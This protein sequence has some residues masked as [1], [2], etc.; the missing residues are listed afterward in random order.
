MVAG[1]IA[2]EK[3]QEGG[4]GVAYNAELSGWSW[5]PY[6]DK[7]LYQIQNLD[8]AN[9]SWGFETPFQDNFQDQTYKAYQ[10]VLSYGALYGREELGTIVIVSAGNNREAGDNVNY[11]NLTN[12]RSVITVGSIN[13]EAD[14]GKLIN[15]SH[16]F[17]NPGA[18]IL[19]S[20]PGSNISSTSNI[21]YNQNGSAF[22]NEFETIQGTSF[23]APIVSGVAAL[24][25]QANPNLGY[26]DVQ[27]ILAYSAKNFQ[28]QNTQWQ[29][30]GAKDWNGGGLRYSADY[31]FGIVN[32]FAA[33]RLAETWNQQNNAENEYYTE[34]KQKAD[35]AIKDNKTI[36]D[37]INIDHNIINA[38]HIEIGVDITHQR[39]GDLVISLTSPSGVE[40]VL[41]N[42]P[43]KAPQSD[44][45]DTGLETQ[46][47]N[48]TFTTTNLWGENSLGNWTIKITDAAAG[49]TGTLNSWTLSL[50]GKYNLGADTYIYTDQYANLAETER[51]TLI[52]DNGGTDTINI[53][54]ITGNITFDLTPGA[55]NQ[56]AGK[57]LTIA[58]NT[59]IEYLLTGDG[60]DTLIGNDA[61][62][63]LYGGRGDDAIYGG[64]GADTITGRQ[65]ADLIQGG[66]GDDTII[67]SID[68][69]AKSGY[70]AWNVGSPNNIINGERIP[71]KP[72]YMT[73]D[74]IDGGQ[75][76]DT[77]QMTDQSEALFLHDHYSPAYQTGAR[78][79]SIETIYAGAGN[80]IIDL[81]SD[82][83][84]A[85]NTTLYGQAGND[86][87]WTSEGDDTIYGGDGEDAI[88]GGIGN[89]K[90]NG[91]AGKDV[92]FGGKGSD[93]FD[94]SN[95]TD[96]TTTDMDIIE[97]FQQGE[98][99]I[100]LSDLFDPSELGEALAYHIEEGDT[101]LQDHN[102]DFAVKIIGEFQLDTDDFIF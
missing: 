91:G 34:I 46:N 9:N 85:P 100:D 101:L 92:L 71:V 94:F 23:S 59:V 29:T 97:D 53:A 42:R 54:A 44:N 19:I 67:Y 1:V 82:K 6:G 73:Y 24:M 89:D 18:A 3:N 49:K 57:S 25:L 11:H 20:A 22:Q 4:I 58:Q 37:T 65:G 28:D 30:N 86:V 64:D 95:L 35:I 74:V 79:I 5:D 7:G 50:Y 84:I 96:S 75:G 43:G 81:T 72:R 51:Q 41:L 14:L 16:P 87:L 61:D 8:I 102:S 31:G 68:A 80:D 60:D 40:S 12:F 77:I 21:L 48:F 93:L 69:E 55:T 98:D 39:I 70:V 27:H 45:T 10:T 13:Q 78:I 62:N 33:V 63:Y 36:T 76:S 38:E 66:A 56:I 52:D 15:P 83:Y 2:A 47:L 99:K 32:A 90:I 17:S 88:N 26:R